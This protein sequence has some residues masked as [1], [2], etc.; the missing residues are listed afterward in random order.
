MRL[1]ATGAPRRMGQQR[2][3]LV[4]A[5]YS[6]CEYFPVLDELDMPDDFDRFIYVNW[7]YQNQGGCISLFLYLRELCLILNAQ[8]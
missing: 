1:V 8:Y 5:P 3:F 4:R 2:G 7:V 6:I